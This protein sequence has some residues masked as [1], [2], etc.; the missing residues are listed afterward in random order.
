MAKAFVRTYKK[1]RYPYNRILKCFRCGVAFEEGDIIIVRKRGPSFEDEF[2][3][4][5]R[6]SVAEEN[7]RGRNRVMRAYHADTCFYAEPIAPRA[8]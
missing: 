7:R 1:K 6:A 8:K 4:G 2:V 3:T 5:R